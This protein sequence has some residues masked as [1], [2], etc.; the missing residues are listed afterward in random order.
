VAVFYR[1][2][3]IALCATALSGCAVHE[4]H[5]DHDLIR[6]TLLDLYTNQVMDNLVRCANGM[7]IIQLDYNNAS[8]TVTITNNIGGSD[9]QA[10]TSSNVLA[11]PAA[12]ASLTRT[13]LTTLMGNASSSNGNQVAVTATPVT[14]SNEV[15]DAYLEYLTQP[16]SLMVSCDP[17]PAGQAHLCKKYD[18]KYFWVPMSYRYSFFRLSLLTTAQRGKALLAPDPY[19]TVALNYEAKLPSPLGADNVFIVLKT[20]RPIP[21]DSGSLVL[22]DPQSAGGAP[23]A[24][25][26]FPFLPYV[27][28]AGEQP[29]STSYV[30]LSIVASEADKV[31]QRVKDSPTGH[32]YLDH[33]QPKAPT[34]DDLLNRVNFQ[35]QQIQFNQLRLPGPSL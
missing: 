15:Y 7:P 22:I 28:P 11:L 6:K 23:K 27:G 12:T 21:N 30:T 29:S 1:L 33:N 20:D 17:P 13:I 24:T 19:Y 26:K 31:I 35:L 9:S 18:G 4:V 32:I 2:S 8:A 10:V 34:T 16:G 25:D 5:K 14:T 3:G